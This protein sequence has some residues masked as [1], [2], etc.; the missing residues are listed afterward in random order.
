VTAPLSGK[1]GGKP[2][3]TLVNELVSMVVAYFRQ[4]TVDPLRSIG[5]FV[6]LG[7]AG[8]ILMSLGAGMAALT[9]VR[10]VQTET[11]RHL[12]GDLTWV[13]YAG[14]FIVAIAGS[15]WAVSRI[16]KG[17]AQR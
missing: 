2:F 17:Q 12:H 16:M 14:G 13:P 15:G 1:G 9:V 11:G 4:E 8:A 5:R 10:L 6:A 3:G 7:F